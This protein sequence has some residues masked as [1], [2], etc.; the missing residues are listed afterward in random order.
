MFCAYVL[1]R[2]NTTFHMYITF[3]TIMQIVLDGVLSQDS[4]DHT[5]LCRKM[6]DEEGFC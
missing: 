1:V 6:P 5:G 2:K 3:Q 4:L